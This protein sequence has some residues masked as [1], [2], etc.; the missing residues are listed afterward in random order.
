V[1]HRPAAVSLSSPTLFS[2]EIQGRV[3]GICDGDTITVLINGHT[4]RVR[5]NGIDCLEKGQ[6]FGARARQLTSDLCFGKIVRV[7]RLDGDR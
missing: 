5:L 7:E 4:D 6:D 2:A 1:A 3:V